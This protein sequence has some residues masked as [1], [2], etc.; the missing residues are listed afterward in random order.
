VDPFIIPAQIV[1]I[2]LFIYRIPLVE[3]IPGSENLASFFKDVKFRVDPWWKSFIVPLVIVG[4]FY[5]AWLGFNIAVI[6]HLPN[7]APY[8][9]VPFLIVDVLILGPI[10]EEIIQCLFLSIIFME[11]ARIVTSRAHI[12]L[13]NG[14]A[15]IFISLWLTFAHFDFRP[16][17]LILRFSLFIVYGA[18]YFASDRNLLPPIISHAVWNALVVIKLDF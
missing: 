16:V 2:L 5:L 8:E 14:I 18:I 10:A 15:L 17:A 3:K 12:I 9:S 6:H 11:L 13:G 1:I 7:P 4:A